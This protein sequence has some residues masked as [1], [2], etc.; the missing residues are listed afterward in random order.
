MPLEQLK[1]CHIFHKLDRIVLL[2]V[3]LCKMA[4][5][6]RDK[7][8]QLPLFLSKKNSKLIKQLIDAIELNNVANLF[9][10]RQEHMPFRKTE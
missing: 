9:C 3:K 1:L 7:T 6:Y 4:T 2:S 5:L 8:V 10:A